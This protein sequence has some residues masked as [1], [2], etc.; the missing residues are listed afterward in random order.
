[1][2]ASGTVRLSVVVAAV[3]GGATLDRCLAALA[4]QQGAP[5]LE[6]LV[7][8]D[9]TLPD[10]PS[11]CARHGATA[12]AMGAVATERRADTFAG[13]HELVD[14]R[15]SAGLRAARG[16][17]LAMLEDRGAPRPDWA[18]TVARLHDQ[19][20]HGA[21]GGPV[22]NSRDTALAWAVYLNDFY[23][24]QPPLPGGPDVYLSDTNV[25]YK[26]AAL[27]SVRN[28]W[29]RTFHETAVHTALHRAGAGLFLSPEPLVEQQRLGLALAPLLSERLEW[30]RLFGHIRSKES[31]LGRR[32]LLA[33]A[34]PG[35]PLLLYARMA[36]R[37]LGLPSRRAFVR[38]SP[39]LLALL[40]AWSAGEA[41]GYVTGK[42]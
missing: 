19:L 32:L 9:T 15:R 25:C 23:R 11:L 35:L 20:P 18:H 1:M 28:V 27:E 6:V 42:F 8:W 33:A 41:V 36:R 34:T 22:A 38:A 29:E 37:Q 16:D 5:P 2:T 12:V 10:V 17:L 3:D 14:L 39:A 26:R 7:P 13:Q 31:T 21:I 40:A 4:A 24:F 30:G